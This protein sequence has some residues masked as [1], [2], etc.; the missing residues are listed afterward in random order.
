VRDFQQHSIRIA[1]HNAL[2]RAEGSVADRVGRFVWQRLKFSHVR[3]K[4][5]TQR[6]G[7]RFTLEQGFE[8]WRHPVFVSIHDSRDRAPVSPVSSVI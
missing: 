6:I 1:V 3:Q 2:D 5:Q 7:R 8:I 4:L